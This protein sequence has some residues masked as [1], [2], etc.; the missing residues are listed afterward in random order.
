MNIA[1]L[2][3]FTIG[4]C[5]VYIVVQDANV[6][7]WLV[8]Q[9]KRLGIELRR[10]WFMVRHYP[11]SPWVRYEIKRNADKLAREILKENKNR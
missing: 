6:F 10:Y 7:D 2:T 9:S 4:A 3:W 8:L 11:D 5:L 1:T